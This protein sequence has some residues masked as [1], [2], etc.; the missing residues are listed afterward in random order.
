MKNVLVTGGRGFIGTHLV[1]QLL[2]NP[3]V[4][5]VYDID[6][7]TYAA[8]LIFPLSRKYH[9]YNI[10][11]CDEEKIYEFFKINNHIDTVF[12]LAAE[13]HVDNSIS[14]PKPF[15]DTNIFGTHVLLDSVRKLT[16]SVKFV[17][18]STDEVFGDLPLGEGEFSEED[19]FKP[20]SP[21]SASKA[22]A[23]H[24]VESYGRTYGIKHVVTFSCN[25]FGPRQHKEK[26]IPK[27]ILNILND[28]PI[29][30]YGEGKNERD[31]IYVGDNAK[32]LMF[33]GE[34]G[35]SG[36]RYNISAGE[37]FSNLDLVEFIKNLMLYAYG[38]DG[39]VKLVTDRL[40]HDLRYAL[41]ADK[42][43]EKFSYQINYN[44]QEKLLQTIHFYVE[45]HKRLNKSFNATKL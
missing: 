4:E 45:I 38:K 31:W 42:L 11:I 39:V 30:V 17:F 21:Y 26:L 15:L 22:S 6:K 23:T 44:F 37:I 36:E 24:L 1:D 2:S 3:K 41:N 28:I 20:S 12:H 5:N 9:F 35:E 7:M 29:P 18:I 10:D 43:R 16:P 8:N 40:G 14:G 19:P 13:S 27:V 25:N 34:F 32:A 33:L